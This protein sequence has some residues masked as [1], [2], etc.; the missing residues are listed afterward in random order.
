MTTEEEI[1]SLKAKR[2][3]SERMGSGYKARIEAI[4]KRLA[5]LEPKGGEQAVGDEEPRD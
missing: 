5:E 1:A 4:D 2:A 3:A